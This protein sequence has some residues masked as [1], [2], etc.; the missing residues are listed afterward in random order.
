VL[1]WNRAFD[2]N[3]FGIYPIAVI[4]KSLKPNYKG[5]IRANK[6][7][8][9]Q[10]RC[11]LTRS[12]TSKWA[13]PASTCAFSEFPAISCGIYDPSHA[14]RPGVS[15]EQAFFSLGAAVTVTVT[16]MVN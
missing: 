5:I 1:I 8:A 2:L 13:S 9:F 7:I 14:G 4:T 3:D 10:K 11:T 6:A 12:P 15:C 16:V